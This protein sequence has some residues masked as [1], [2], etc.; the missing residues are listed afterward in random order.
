MSFVSIERVYAYSFFVLSA[1]FLAFVIFIPNAVI[2]LGFLLLL[3][4]FVTFSRFIFLIRR[5]KQKNVE[6]LPDQIITSFDKEADNQKNNILKRLISADYIL[7]VTGIVVGVLWLGFCT[8][9]PNEIN[10]IKTLHF[11]FSQ[12][13]YEHYNQQ[14]LMDPS[15]MG[16]MQPFVA[17]ILTF[18]LLCS[19][20]WSLSASR[21]FIRLNMII[22]L[23]AFFM[24][25][26]VLVFTVG[27]VFLFQWPDAHFL[28]GGGIGVSKVLFLLHPNMAADSASFFMARFLETGFIGAYG[29]YLLF[30]PALSVFFHVITVR[31]RRKMLA[32][33]GIITVG[34]L[35]MM[36]MFWLYSAYGKAVMV[37]GWFV[38]LACWG[39]S[40]FKTAHVQR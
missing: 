40:G 9:N 28:I 23:P 6:S 37:M 39:H 8:A 12:F 38:V 21:F 4:S 25:L 17:L 16:K 30:M 3:T 5:N 11:E 22:F 27:R 35:L 29:V 34:L 15:L 18:F 24:G 7:W 1:L 20:H 32:W 26:V 33:V 19:L 10:A 13:F 2:E 36:D 31:R 14:E